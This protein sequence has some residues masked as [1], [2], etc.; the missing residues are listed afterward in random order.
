MHAAEGVHVCLKP[1]SVLCSGGAKPFADA[2]PASAPENGQIPRSPAALARLAAAAASPAPAQE[3]SAAARD[4]PISAATSN[5]ESSASEPGQAAPLPESSN[6]LQLSNGNVAAAEPA[7]AS[8]AAPSEQP[9]AAVQHKQGPAEQAP[10]QSGTAQ[11]VEADA[12]AK[13]APRPH[14]AGPQADAKKK[15]PQSPKPAA[16]APEITPPAA[17]AAPADKASGEA[18]APASSKQEA[19]PAAPPKQAADGAAQ[20][21]GKRKLLDDSDSE[22]SED[23][24]PLALRKGFKVC[25]MTCTSISGILPGKPTLFCPDMCKILP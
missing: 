23:D 12:G 24:I 13:P 22:D 9:A 7:A 25:T 6:G 18:P 14:S 17:A 15:P 1:K 2:R 19:A 3:Y 5:K 11:P 16:T 8:K 21:N 10:A 4:E 20:A